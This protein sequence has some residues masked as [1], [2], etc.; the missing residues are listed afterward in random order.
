MVN[1]QT[2]ESGEKEIGIFKALQF[3]SIEDGT[4]PEG[5]GEMKRLGRQIHHGISES[6]EKSLEAV[7]GARAG[8][9]G[10]RSMGSKEP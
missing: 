2:Q 7:A 4:V 8:V 9:A 1:K 5:P 6:E 10:S 3:S